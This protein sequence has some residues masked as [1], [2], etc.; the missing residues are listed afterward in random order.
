[1]KRHRIRVG[2][3]GA[4]RGLTFARQAPAAGMELAAVCD[5]WKERLEEAGADLGVATYSNYDAFLE[6]DMDAVILA[7]YF[8]EHAPFAVK[9]L[10]MGFHVMSECSACHTLGEGVA[11]ARA[12]EKCGRI[13]MFAEN[14]PYM[15]YNQEM[16]RLFQEGVIGDF[17]YGEGEYVHPDS[18]RVHTARSVG[19]DHWRN[20]I[21]ATYYC[22]H[23]L[24]PIMYITGTRP[25][26]VNGFIV[27][28]DHNDPSMTEYVRVSDTAA[29][30]M[31]RMDN[32]AVVKSLHGN[33]RGHQNYVRIHGN[34]GMME[35][36][37]IG[38]NKNALRVHLAP[39]GREQAEHEERVYAPKF[40]HHPREAANAGHGGGDFFTNYEFA[41]A[42][43]TGTQPYLDVYKAIDMSIA[44]I[45][46]YR[47]ALAEGAPVSVPDFRNEEVRKQFEHDAWS[48]DPRRAGPGQPFPSILGRIEPSEE[49]VRFSRQVWAEQG[50]RE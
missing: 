4:G 47:S 22:T 2:V 43:R 45:L 18:A 30:I 5:T 50:Y 36:A 12:V 11:L 1:M 38:K 8:H 10:E 29:A 23:S 26:K 7:N 9:A 41:E 32:G 35:N 24:A 17:L 42:I 33:L 40:P 46:A 39:H 48:P 21:P 28:Y 14:Y 49:A 13:Y 19:M 31:L 25:V 27:P 37:R 44:G 20:W 16:R 3:V 15:V 34:K 6:H